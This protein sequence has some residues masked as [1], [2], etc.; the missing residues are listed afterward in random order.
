M[1]VS[2]KYGM[3]CVLYLTLFYSC[4]KE[5]SYEGGAPSSGYLLKD[6][7]N[8][9]T[10]VTVA[11]NYT[12]S[13]NLTD[14]NFLE[15]QAHVSRAGSYFITSDT[16]NGYSFKAS[17]VFKDTGRMSV[18]LPASGKPLIAGSNSFHIYY[19]SSV[20]QV[21][22]VVADTIIGAVATT[23]PDHFPLTANSHW[24]YDDLSYPGDSIVKKITGISTQNSTPHQDVEEYLSFFSAVNKQYYRKTSVDYFRYTSV[25]GFTSALNYSPSIYDDINFLKENIA[26]GDSWYSNTYSGRT[27]LSTQ[28]I[29][30][31]YYFRCID[32]DATVVVKGKTFEHVYKIQMIPEVA[33]PGANPKA[34]GEIHTSYFAKG[35]GLIYSEFYNDVLSHPVL[36]ITNWVVN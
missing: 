25:S 2:R 22:V 14:S 19:A 12:V 1:I 11:G 26:T 4:K 32:A 10:L 5:Y 23:N 7:T 9:C 24:S 20:C 17:G 3:L 6:S 33:D 34:T 8:N 18:H 15:V 13:K 27:S 31:R 29:V 28:I 16:N 30:L 21:K 35:V 36:Q